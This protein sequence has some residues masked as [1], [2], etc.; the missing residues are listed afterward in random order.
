MSIP[1]IDPE[2]ERE[3]F[4][5]DAYQWYT[6]YWE[7]RVLIDP[8]W[9]EYGNVVQGAYPLILLANYAR[10][11]STPTKIE[12]VYPQYLR[13]PHFQ[14]RLDS[15]FFNSEIRYVEQRPDIAIQEQEITSA[16][17]AISQ[18]LAASTEGVRQNEEGVADRNVL[19]DEFTGDAGVRTALEL[20]RSAYLLDCDY[21]LT[22]NPF[23]LQSAEQIR[24]VR[25]H[26]CSVE[27][28]IPALERFLRAAGVFLL[29]GRP[30][31]VEEDMAD[32]L[33]P[34]LET[35]GVGLQGV[36]FQVFYQ[37]TP[38][39]AVYIQWFYSVYRKNQV[40]KV[41][42]FGRSAFFHRF[43]FLEYASDLVQHHYESSTLFAPNDRP[44][45]DHRFYVLYHA[46]SFYLNISAFLDNLA[47]LINYYLD[48]GYRETATDRKSPQFRGYCG[49]G[50]A[51]FLKKLKGQWE[52]LHDLLVR[53]SFL[54]W[55]RNLTVKRDPAAHRESLYMAAIMQTG[56]GQ[57]IT[58]THMITETA[59]GYVMFDIPNGVI[60]DMKKLNDL[61]REIIALPL[62]DI[63]SSGSGQVTSGDI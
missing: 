43:P 24:R 11:V 14:R 59:D 60:Q 8:Y 29:A 33:N 44:R 58:D 27:T 53:P 57:L 46:N 16:L 51:H 37:M 17:E 55:V 13:R 54:E 3:P 45:Q 5:R 49:L 47:W 15:L 19:F 52:G 20:V 9:V 41:M 38:P 40:D 32:L 26:V 4:R 28:L 21:I 25:A 6:G 42:T 50:R 56:T 48:L 35:M 62:P 61:M 63:E 36:G 10:S 31:S 34:T 7:T 39:L 12:L 23:L 22:S 18:N 1:G 2:N 30:Q